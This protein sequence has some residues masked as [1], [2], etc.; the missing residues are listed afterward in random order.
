[1]SLKNLFYLSAIAVLLA[2][3]YSPLHAQAQSDGSG[4]CNASGKI[5]SSNIIIYAKDDAFTGDSAQDNVVVYLTP[6]GSV[7][8]EIT[9]GVT[10]TY[11]ASTHTWTYT[12]PIFEGYDPAQGLDYMVTH[13]GRNSCTV[14]EATNE[15]NGSGD[16]NGGVGQLPA[17]QEPI[18]KGPCDTAVRKAE[19]LADPGSYHDNV[20][21]SPQSKETY[22]M[23]SSGQP[24][25]ETHYPGTLDKD[26]NP[27]YD[28]YECKAERGK[29]TCEKNKDK[30]WVY[31]RAFGT[32]PETSCV[33][34]IGFTKTIINYA[35]LIAALIAGAMLLKGGFKYVVSRG[36]ATG[37]ME[38]RDEILHASIG[39][40][41]LAVAYVAIL[42]LQGSLGFLGVDLV[43]PF[44]AVFGG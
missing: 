39:I 2:L 36:S 10:K 18:K 24:T 17:T 37:L 23:A 6:N 31:V 44:A 20:C 42:F 4:Q 43:G 35:L 22:N 38:A 14:A 19:C 15:G 12:F 21:F 26:G 32:D 33:S 27:I 30:G 41:L 29:D 16:G 3:A 34:F 1:M 7:S 9:E 8:S 25:G 28:S 11:D 5:T 40:V 13:H